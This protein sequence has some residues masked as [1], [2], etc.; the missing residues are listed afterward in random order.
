M[1]CTASP[2]LSRKLSGSKF[3]TSPTTTREPEKSAR[4]AAAKDAVN[5]SSSTETV[6][7]DA[8]AN[9]NESAPIPHPRSATERTPARANTAGRVACCAP[10]S[11]K[12]IV[13]ALSPNFDSARV[14]AL[15]RPRI[16]AVS[17]GVNPRAR[18]RVICLSECSWLKGKSA[19]AASNACWVKGSSGGNANGGGGTKST[20][21][22]S[23]VA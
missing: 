21:G 13:R 1:P 17:S 6:A 20:I 18:S 8:R 3:V 15:T 16:L 5:G 2:V 10:C 19:S 7:K 23:V 9:S 14:R 11:V 22:L 12:N 4:F